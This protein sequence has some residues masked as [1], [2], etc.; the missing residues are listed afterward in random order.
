MWADWKNIIEILIMLCIT[1]VISVVNLLKYLSDLK[2]IKQ[3]FFLQ[4]FALELY[5]VYGY[6]KQKATIMPK[7]LCTFMTFMEHL[8]L[9]T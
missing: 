6:I 1:L 5:I 3:S 8:I 2:S 7:L 4:K 9:V